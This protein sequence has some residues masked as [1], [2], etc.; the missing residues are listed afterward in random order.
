M[1]N[2]N[3]EA[4]CFDCL[5]PSTSLRIAGEIQL[6][7]LAR[8][9]NLGLAAVVTSLNAYDSE[10]ECI[11]KCFMFGPEEGRR[12]NK[13]FIFFQEALLG[14][15]PWLRQGSALLVF[16]QAGRGRNSLVGKHR[17]QRGRSQRRCCLSS[18]FR[19]LLFAP[20]VIRVAG[21]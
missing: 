3:Q 19:I 18:L 1:Q 15:S 17:I 6:L 13:C 7:S 4:L 2:Q 11:W 8:F 5:H 10:A 14:L 20:Q 16:K 21:N 9:C 12:G